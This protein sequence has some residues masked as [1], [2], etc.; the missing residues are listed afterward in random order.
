M[1]NRGKEQTDSTKPET[2]SRSLRS[3]DD[4]TIEWKNEKFS[5]EST[6]FTNKNGEVE[7]KKASVKIVMLLPGGKE[8]LLAEAPINLSNH[9]GEKFHQ[10]EIDLGDWSAKKT[11][12]SKGIIMKKLVYKCAITIVKEKER[13][14]FEACCEYREKLEYLRVKAAQSKGLDK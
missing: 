14:M 5:R 10:A 3:S 9:F 4:K 1:F 2:V 11:D 6:F 7:E 13:A 12:E 8:H